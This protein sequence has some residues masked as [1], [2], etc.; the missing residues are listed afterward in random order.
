[1]IALEP[2]GD[3]AYLARFAS[4]AEACGWMLEVRKFGLVGV[5][6]VVLAYHNVAVFVDPDRMDL[7]ALAR[8]LASISV[9]PGEQ[10]EGRRVVVPVLYD[11]EDLPDVA[12]TLRLSIGE[13]VT[14]HSGRDYR[15]QAVGFL[16]G[17]PYAGDL[18]SRLSGL[19]RR[20]Q[21]RTRVPAGSVAVVGTQTGIYPAESPGGWHLIGRTPLRI[22][23]LASGHFPIAA[24]D[25]LRFVAVDEPEFRSLSG[26][27]LESEVGGATVGPSGL[28]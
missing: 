19:A 11:G 8:R 12:A 27:V 24:G 7:D 28:G 25:A 1:M 16:P 20:A 6:D 9:A 15:V 14:L 22:V 4:D 5:V 21:P 17:F 13:V 23:D 18:D 3:R 2:L 10:P 26:K